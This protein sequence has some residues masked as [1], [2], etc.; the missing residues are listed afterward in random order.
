MTQN[1]NLSIR[2]IQP[3]ERQKFVIQFTLMTALA[4][5]ISSFIEVILLKIPV[6]NFLLSRYSGSLN[7]SSLV[8]LR[9]VQEVPKGISLG[10]FQWLVIRNYIPSIWW[11]L[12]TISGYILCNLLPILWSNF[13]ISQLQANVFDI[14]LQSILIEPACYIIFGIFQSIVLSKYINQA[15]KWIVIPPLCWLSLGIWFIPFDIFLAR[16]LTI[17]E[18]AKFSI[19]IGI[20]KLISSALVLGIVPSFTLCLLRKK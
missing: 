11:V 1:A 3:S 13:A 9:L 15:W 20:V 8:I 14:G 4:L 19:L 6:L 12:V 5:L 17:S 16:F 7:G 10:I 2:L 18:Y